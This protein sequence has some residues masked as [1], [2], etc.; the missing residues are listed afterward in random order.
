MLRYAV[1]VLVVSLSCWVVL[2]PRALAKE[3]EHLYKAQCAS[4][5]GPDGSGKTRAGTKLKLAD[6]RSEHVQGQTDADLFA[7][8]AHGVGHKEYPHAFLHRGLTPAQITKLVTYLRA[9]PKP[10]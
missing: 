10:K 7:S 1:R 8:I 5:H 9:L 3:G 4:C 2:A 6:L